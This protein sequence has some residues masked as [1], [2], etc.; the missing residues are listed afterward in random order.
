MAE[1]REAGMIA[2][3]LG[4]D[5]IVLV[6]DGERVH[7]IG[8]HCTH[9]HG[10]LV[11]GIVVGGTIRCPWHHA[12][13]DLRSGAVLRA[14]AIG[15]L[16]V[17]NVE[18]S[19]GRYFVG[20]KKEPEGHAPSG[21]P[22]PVVIVGAGAAGVNVADTL[23]SEGFAGRILLISRESDLP[24]DKPNL[25]KDYLAGAA[26]ADWL[27]LHP[28]PYY[29]EQRI[30]LLLG[31]TVLAVDTAAKSVTT[32]SGRRIPYGALVLA[33]GAAAR[34]LPDAE[35]RIH[36]LRTR[37]DAER[38]V[39]KAGSAKRA[40]VVGSSFIGLEVAASLRQRGLEVTVTSPDRTPL[41][42]VLGREV[43]ERIRTIHESHGVVFR[44]GDSRLDEAAL[45]DFDLIVAGIGVSPEIALAKQAGL[46]AADGILVDE[47]LETSV[48][49]IYACGDVAAWPGGPMKER[50]RVE[51]W[52]VAGRQG[53]TVA[54]N[55]LGKRDRFDAVP[56]FWSAHFDVVIAYVG[57]GSG[58][59][60]IEVRGS[61][62]ANDAT[63][64][65]RRAGVVTA[66]ATIGRDRISL[67]AEAALERADWKA[68]NEVL[69][70]A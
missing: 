52:V 7:A 57:H 65:W 64:V 3:R 15:G 62:E 67:A 51:H 41:E 70:G 68:L 19:D 18:E 37:R 33:T 20:S 8:A 59:D 5:E 26:P 34:T 24:Y 1:L 17:W 48:P 56:F 2:G 22:D 44:L 50:L 31:E 38:I 66:V 16:P 43:G 30:D 61:L 40:A 25:S 32:V 21:G 13:F 47:F 10:P 39:E 69:Q 42:R 49:G 9:Y 60:D 53:Q 35:N 11:E 46:A 28:H 36:Y 27:P 23:R 12:C 4:E 29:E 45:R 6:R 63:I 58:D 54:R 55:I 14:P